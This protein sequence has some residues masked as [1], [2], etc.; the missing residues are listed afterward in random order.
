MERPS[1]AAE[2]PIITKKWT[3]LSKAWKEFSQQKSCFFGCAGYGITEQN[4]MN[5]ICNVLIHDRQCS[6]PSEVE[7]HIDHSQRGCCWCPIGT[8]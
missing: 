5:Q 8:Y 6:R 1:N 2:R 7:V 4:K 3:G